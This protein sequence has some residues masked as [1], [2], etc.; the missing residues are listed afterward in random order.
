MAT[1][2]E[3][4]RNPGPFITTLFPYV[5]Q[6][7]ATKD[8]YIINEVAKVIYT[9]QSL[10]GGGNVYSKQTVYPSLNKDSLN[11]RAG[12]TVLIKNFQ[13]SIDSIAM[14][15]N[16]SWLEF[17]KFV[18]LFYQLVNPYEYF[19]DNNQ[20]NL[21]DMCPPPHPC[22]SGNNYYTYRIGMYRRPQVAGEGTGFNVQTVIPGDGLTESVVNIG[23]KLNTSSSVP[24]PPP[25]G[26]VC[27]DLSY[28]SGRYFVLNS[29]AAADNWDVIWYDYNGTGV[30]PVYTGPTGTITYHSVEIDPTDTVA[31]IQA[32]T[33]VTVV[34]TGNWTKAVATATCYD[35][36][37][38][39][40]GICGT[41]PVQPCASVIPC[42]FVTSA[43]K[44]TV[45]KVR[46][47]AEDGRGGFEYPVTTM[48]ASD[49]IALANNLV[50]DEAWQ[51]AHNDLRVPYEELTYDNRYMYIKSLNALGTNNTSNLNFNGYFI[52]TPAVSIITEIPLNKGVLHNNQAGNDRLIVKN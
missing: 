42:P 26:K 9:K 10:W 22:L 19:L 30:Q 29:N 46:T 36:S 12:Q 32:K 2:Q 41:P 38:T 6:A 4:L 31:E 39:T 43:Y 27:W 13:Y 14:A 11:R 37:P 40:F 28:I 49:G 5:Q 16:N 21:V 34:N 50:T 23:F 7:I 25:A 52:M 33:D 15:D 48:R 8:P 45:I 17:Q 24:C 35:K 1:V 51:N 47:N 44:A 18:D 3:L 20:L